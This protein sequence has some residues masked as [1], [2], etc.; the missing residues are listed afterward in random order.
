MI[1]SIDGLKTLCTSLGMDYFSWMKPIVAF[2]ENTLPFYSQGLGWFIPVI[3][4]MI[5]TGILGRVF[6]LSIVPVYKKVTS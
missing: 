5:V 1:S 3:L 4:V 2:Y 6:N